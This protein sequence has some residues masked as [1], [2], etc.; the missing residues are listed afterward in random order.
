MRNYFIINERAIAQTKIDIVCV[1]WQFTVDK[2]EAILH[3]HI[4][5]Y[6]FYYYYDD[7]FR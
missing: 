6:Y 1:L 4:P 2:L 3:A 5:F 7:D